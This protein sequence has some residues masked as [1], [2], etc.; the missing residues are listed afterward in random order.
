MSSATNSTAG[1]P[2]GF[3]GMGDNDKFCEE[4]CLLR[5]T[6]NSNFD[7]WTGAKCPIDVNGRTCS[8]HIEHCGF[9]DNQGF[10]ITSYLVIVIAVLLVLGAIGF[11]CY[12]KHIQKKQRINGY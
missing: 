12:R 10:E 11:F 6:E 8:S 5:V 9:C 2:T 1:E 4:A 7:R 3:I